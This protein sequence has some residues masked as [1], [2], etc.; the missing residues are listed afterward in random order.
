M[1]MP[2]MRISANRRH[3]FTLVELLVVI[4][5]IGVLVAL[6]LPAV[7]AARE[8]ARRS[9][10]SNNLKQLGLAAL[11]FE[12]AQ[13]AFPEGVHPEKWRSDG[14]LRQ[15]GSNHGDASIGWGGLILPYIEQSSLGAQYKSIPRYPDYNWETAAGTG[16]Q[17][18]AG[19]LS[20][21]GLPFFMCPSDVMPTINE[22]Y[23]NAE[24][25]FAK[26]NYVGVAGA[27]GGDDAANVSGDHPSTSGMES[28]FLA[29][30]NPVDIYLN[31]G[32]ND[33]QRNLYNRTFG[34]LLAGVE[35]KIA[36]VSD[37]TSN[38]FMIGERH[39]LAATMSPADP[40]Y[41]STP[42][43]AYWTGSIR[44]KWVN[45]T[46]TNVRNHAG[47]LLNGTSAYGT[48]SL[49]VGGGH[50]TRADGSTAFVS[51]SIDG[52]TFEALG[53]RAGEDLAAGG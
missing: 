3:G 50:F 31:S 46:L 42:R 5:I 15:V 35:T 37:G 16:G 47:F 53:T 45:S 20:K 10:C 36:E 14:A 19:D 41:K 21:T 18:K 17:P 44:A 51:D 28:S 7:Q 25:P 8:A 24:D 30:L 34:V 11:N 43:A 4:A 26:S 40:T 6:L 13:G 33:D 32:L 23:N 39:G 1:E 22:I 12:S 49:H 27:Y 2:A 48:S 9:Q 29:Y 38:T 52:A